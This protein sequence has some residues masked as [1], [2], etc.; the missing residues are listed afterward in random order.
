MAKNSAANSVVK[1]TFTGNRLF[2]AVLAIFYA[3]KIAG[4]IRYD[5]S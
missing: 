1:N 2:R 5:C 4:G 3:K